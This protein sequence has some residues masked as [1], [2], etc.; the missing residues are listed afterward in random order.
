MTKTK[1]KTILTILLTGFVIQ[2]HSIELS[3][4]VI[5][6]GKDTI[7]NNQE[8]LA[9]PIITKLVKTNGGKPG[10]GIGYAPPVYYK[11]DNQLFFYEYFHDTV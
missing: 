7:R 1:T 5:S 9:S 8:R 11:K 3:S 10:I 6:K 4:G 2:G